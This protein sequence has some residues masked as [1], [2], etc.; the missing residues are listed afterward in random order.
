[1]GLTVE[2]EDDDIEME[3]YYI[4]KVFDVKAPVALPTANLPRAI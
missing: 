1:L 4:I 2:E 3:M